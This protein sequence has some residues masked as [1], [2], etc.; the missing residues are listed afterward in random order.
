MQHG[1]TAHGRRC[2]E[3]VGGGAGRGGVRPGHGG[4][5][6]QSGRHLVG[7]GGSRATRARCSLSSARRG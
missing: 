2:G 4:Q 7:G 3:E 5:G 1:G 6:R